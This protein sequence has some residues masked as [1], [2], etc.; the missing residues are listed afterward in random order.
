MPF[1][2]RKDASQNYAGEAGKDERHFEG[3]FCRRMLN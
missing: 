1:Y 2:L 3:I